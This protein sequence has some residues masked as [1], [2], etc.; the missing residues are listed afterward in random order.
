MSKVIDLVMRLQDGVTSVLS[1]INARMQDTAVAA[2]SAGRRV[3]KVGEGISGI[4]DKLMPVSA[5]IVGA[6][7]AAVHA[8]VGFD[9]AVTSAG[10]KAGA[11]AEEIEQLREVAKGLGN[12][13]PISATEAAVAMDGLAASGMNANQIM[14]TLPSIV[15][16]SV[17]SGESLEVTS[18]V[19]AGA[20]NT[21]GL[22]TGNV[23][24]NSQ[25]M[26]D[27]IQMAANKSKLGMADFGVAMQYAGAPAAALGVQV[28]ELATSMAIMSNNNIEASTSG[29]SL[30]MMLSRLVDPPKEAS[31]ALAK[32]G[33]SAID[34]TGKF[35]GLGNVYDQ[36]RSKMQGLTEAEKFK[37]AGD[38]AGTES[39]SALLAVLNTSTED[40]N[41]LR[42][43]MDDAS[44]SSKKQA[45][46][47]KQTLLGTFKDLAS[48]VEAL[49]ISFAEVLQPKIKSVANSLGTLATWFKN[50][51]PAVK[52]MI[53]NIGL[54]VV[55]FTAL[56]KILGPVVSGVGSLMRVYADI[57]KVLAGSPIQN[58][59][60]E[61]SIHGITKAYNLLGSVAGRVIPWI[62]RMLPMAFTGPVG[63]AVGAIALIG[64]AIW[65]NWDTVRPVLESFGRG[66]MGLARYVGDVVAKIWTHLQPFVT[67]LAET[68]GKGIDRLMASF[69]RLGKVLSPVLDF[70]M[71]T[72]GA[73]AAVLIGGP[74]AVAIGHLVLG[75][76]IAVAAIEGILTGLVVAITGI[77]DGISQILS[78]I[79]DFI[80]GVFTGNWALAWSG[81]V[82]IFSGIVTGITAIFDGVIEGVRATINS[83]ISSINGI[84]FDIPD[85]V[86]GVGG[87]SFGPL[88]IPMLYSGT[89]NWSGGPA[90]VHDRGAEIINLPSGSQVIP[91]AQSLRSAY[92]QGKRSGNGG[93]GGLQLTIQNLNV[94]NDGKSVE[95]LAK[96]IMEHIHYEMSIRS[97]N[98]MEGAV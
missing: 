43:A 39:A 59:L 38:I 71:Y 77:I 92:D 42:Q 35:V 78:G 87:K 36:L 56:T 6:G 20:L 1:G 24:E 72:V 34:S 49:G 5:A 98:K 46:L 96:E 11:T 14:G 69:Q 19:V 28:E 97:I 68:F 73:I 41:E 16:A 55:G 13:F 75:F 61:A 44:G 48:K 40:Y 23:A 57:G 22:M 58:K 95:E 53:V 21:W 15:E 76:T 60:L 52:D 90:M 17:A 3:Q 27:V 94:R 88:N 8:F 31:E 70:I 51:N 85:W 86:P 25:R 50:L 84:S 29:R 33:V 79:I 18:N 2:N 93:G 63:L 9:S 64:I 10:A 32:L 67:K 7:A 66:F 89:D 45:D 12:D 37:L 83:L 81:V 30:R 62:A 47:M 65:K 91:H 4:G 74:L 26:A 80:T 54:S 82:E